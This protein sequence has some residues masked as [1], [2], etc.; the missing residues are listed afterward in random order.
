MRRR[1]G[2]TGLPALQGHG[3]L[4]IAVHTCQEV[5]N[6]SLPLSP[7]EPLWDMLLA[8]YNWMHRISSTW[9]YAIVWKRKMVTF[10]KGII[11]KKS[12]MDATGIEV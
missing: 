5:I 6:R 9:Q 7:R 10:D 1:S 2:F 3:H 4:L 12:L 11:S 8:D